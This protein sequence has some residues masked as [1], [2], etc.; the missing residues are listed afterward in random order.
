[1]SNK[2]DSFLDSVPQPDWNG[3]IGVQDTRAGGGSCPP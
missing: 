3:H 2:T 1:M